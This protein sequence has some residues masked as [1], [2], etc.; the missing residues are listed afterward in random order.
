MD[1]FLSN[2]HNEFEAFV[3]ALIPFFKQVGT[4]LLVVISGPSG[5]GKDSVIQCMKER[6]L[7]FR[8]V[9][10]V[11][12]RARREGEVNGV[13]YFFVSREEFAELIEAGEMLEY[14][15]VYNDYKGVPKEQVSLAL[16]SGDDVVMRVDVQGAATLRRLYPG[17]LMVFL[18]TEDERIMIERLEERN[19]EDPDELKLRIATARK[20]LERVDEFEYLVINRQNKLDETVDKILAIM[21]AEHQRV[22]PRDLAS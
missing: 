16:E 6:K 5:V 20:E 2:I 17:A 4:Q 14:A 18:M 15:Y 19:S 13:D 7:P 11:T 1:I 22:R 3:Q 9:V 12:T 10:T 21:A 8:F